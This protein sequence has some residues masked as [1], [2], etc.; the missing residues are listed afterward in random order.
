MFWYI[1]I[2]DRTL[3][4][5]KKGGELLACNKDLDNPNYG[6]LEKNWD[7]TLTQRMYPIRARRTISG[8][9]TGF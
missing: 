4:K 7:I 2:Y 9:S 6:L 8:Q 5:K 3:M 1:Y